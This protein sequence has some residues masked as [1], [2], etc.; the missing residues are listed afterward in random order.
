LG[1]ILE[2]G[3]GCGRILGFYKNRGYDIIGTDVCSGLLKLQEFRR[4][5]GP[6]GRLPPFAGR[7]SDTRESLSPFS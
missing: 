6:K 3:C 2:A 5:P 7:I 1:K 4:K